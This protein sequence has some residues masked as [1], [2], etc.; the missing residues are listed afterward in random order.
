VFVVREPGK[1]E[2]RRVKLG[3]DSDGQ[4]AILDGL[5][6]GE[7]IVVSAQFLIDSESKLREATAKMLEAPTQPQAESIPTLHDAEGHKHD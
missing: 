3:L 5:D 1:F 2:P 4:V 7:E 6:E